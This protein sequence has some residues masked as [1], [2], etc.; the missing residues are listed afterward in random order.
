MSVFTLSILDQSGNTMN[1]NWGIVSLDIHHAF[2]R[3][4][5]AELIL[6][7]GDLARQE[8]TI[9]NEAFF[10]PGKEIEIQIRYEG[11]TDDTSIFKGVVMKQ[12]VE[13]GESGL[14]LC[15]SL[16][17]AAIKLTRQRK[18]RIFKDQTDSDA[19]SEIIS[20]HGLEEGNI[21]STS[22][23]HAEL[24]QYH[25]SDWDF[26]LTRAEAN[27]MLIKVKDGVISSLPIEISGPAT[28]SFEL[29]ISEIIGL[30]LEADAESQ[31]ANIQ[32]TAWD[33]AN[34]ALFGTVSG[35]DP[36]IAIGDLD[37]ASIASATGGETFDLKTA[38]LQ[39]IDELQAWAN[40]RLARSRFSKITGRI[41]IYGKAD[42]MPGMVVNIAGVS[43]RFNGDSLVT[44]LRHRIG[45]AGW[46]TDLQI[47]MSADL[48][49]NRFKDI[50]I[51]IAAGL[52]PGVQGLQ[53]G[54]VADFAEDPNGE[55]R[56]QVLIPGISEDE[57]ILWA[58][59]L[60]PD[61]GPNRGFFFRPE[62]GDEVILG[63]L[64]ND[65]RHPIILGSLYGSVNSP[66]VDAIDADNF[67]KGI[68]SKE[69]IKLIMDDEKKSLTLLTSD[70]RKIVLDE[71]SAS[72]TL[73]DEHGNEI[74]M[75]S[76]GIQ[77][78]SAT[79][80]LLEASGNVEIK[81]VQVDVK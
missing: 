81:G 57:G 16:K 72:I 42:L 35:S 36:N 65:P 60:S 10:E 3:I 4:S 50:Q 55:F 13:V 15:I 46:I 25:C 28:E 44:E 17:D 11:E 56:V 74:I 29:G 48:Y 23:V 63:F 8:F 43:N 5:S 49:V 75:D 1:L 51:P 53:V 45:E 52:L 30:E 41:S 12:R 73:E 24:V 21:A 33:P 34:Q 9:S 54:V 39:D 69:G 40:G 64:N 7:D 31:Y 14:F 38:G 22:P 32:A 61:A 2:N 71:D 26:L 62:V 66:P 58:R 59:M 20:S 80:L 47:G 78:K 18:S 79:D 37:A 27:G 76:G 70:S 6:M 68:F 77:I 67:I 19:F